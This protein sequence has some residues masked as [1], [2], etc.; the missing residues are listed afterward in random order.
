MGKDDLF[1]RHVDL[2]LC[3]KINYIDIFFCI[4]TALII[5]FREE[6]FVTI[7]FLRYRRLRDSTD[8]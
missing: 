3:F 4:Q 7:S 8:G 2:S 6:V 1:G 5:S